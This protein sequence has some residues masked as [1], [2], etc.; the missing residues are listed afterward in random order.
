MK[1]ARIYHNN[2]HRFTHSRL[3]QASPSTKLATTIGGTK[4]PIKNTLIP[5]ERLSTTKGGREWNNNNEW[6]RSSLGDL[7]DGVLVVLAGG[8]DGVLG[9]KDFFEGRALGDAKQLQRALHSHLER[10]RRGV[11]RAGGR[12][13]RGPPPRAGERAAPPRRRGRVP[14][15]EGSTATAAAAAAAEGEGRRR[16]HYFPLAALAWSLKSSVRALL[17]CASA[18]AVADDFFQGEDSALWVG[19]FSDIS[20]AFSPRD[21]FG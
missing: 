14:A 10:R 18:S 3:I 6:R 20:W 2:P 21:E 5:P 12:Q 16:G 9:A 7:G 8:E 11:V 17:L 19:V 15:E 4:D 1:G 13:A